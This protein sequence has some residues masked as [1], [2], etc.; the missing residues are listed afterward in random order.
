MKKKSLAGLLI[1]ASLVLLVSC[2]LEREFDSLRAARVRLLGA[3]DPGRFEIPKPDTGSFLGLEEALDEAPA[4]AYRTLP[5][6]FE[7]QS[8]LLLGC[9]E[10]ATALP[11][12]FAEVVSASHGRVDVIALVNDTEEREYV[13]ETLRDYDLPP[14]SVR[15]LEI[16]HDTMWIRDY[17]PVLVGRRDGADAVL[18]AVYG[19]EERVEDD[20]VPA[21]IARL[22]G[23]RHVKVPIEVD[24]GNLLSNG[25]GLCLSTLQLIVDND[26]PDPDVRRA[27]RIYYGCEMTVLLEPLIGESTGH[28]DMF[29]TFTSRNTVVVGSYDPDI[30]AENAGVLDRNAA[31]LR[32]VETPRGRLRVVRIPMPPRSDE[33]WRTYT[34]VIYANGRLM[35]PVYTDDDPWRRRDVLAAYA[36]LLPGWELI[37][38]VADELVESGGALHC[39]SRNLKLVRNEP[40]LSALE[41]P[42]T[43]DG[44]IDDRSPQPPF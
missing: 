12:V 18:D 37:P 39:I 14:D 13:L 35:V 6:E 19:E 44:G 5:G 42:E 41:Q 17:G 11:D 21:R 3:P 2:L 40:D 29:A 15:F 27:L 31:M 33:H 43:C 32:R 23:K 26:A 10:L 24:G 7:T 38:I 36:E 34:N 4:G 28:V 22:L 25:D 16:R 8:A 20:Q 9:H 1:T 30:D